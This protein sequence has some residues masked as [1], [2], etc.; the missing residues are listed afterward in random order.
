M[1][2][3]DYDCPTFNTAQ[4]TSSKLIR[5]A[6]QNNSYLVH[7]KGITLAIQF[8][9][10]KGDG[11]GISKD[12]YRSLMCGRRKGCSLTWIAFFSNYWGIS[13]IELMGTDFKTRDK[14][15]AM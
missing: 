5:Q 10:F 4:S 14:L 2:T 13:L 8:A 1:Y 12:Y 9:S 6:L 7:R 11:V 3:Y 15:M